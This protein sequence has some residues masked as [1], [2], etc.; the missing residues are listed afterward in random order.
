MCC[1][2]VRSPSISIAT[3]RVSFSCCISGKGSA[4]LP[5]L[6]VHLCRL[7]SGRAGVVHRDVCRG[8]LCMVPS[9]R[10]RP[11]GV[12]SMTSGLGA[13]RPSIAARSFA[14]P[15]GFMNVSYHQFIKKCYTRFPIDIAPSLLRESVQSDQWSVSDSAHK[16]VHWRH[17]SNRRR[18]F[19]NLSKT[20]CH[21]I[22]VRA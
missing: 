6:R 12:F 17:C 13:R 3:R 7:L 21:Y 16:S 2:R 5:I 18:S 9:E 1:S 11:P 4:R 15:P 10:Q 20:Q 8:L 14:D 22:L 19:E